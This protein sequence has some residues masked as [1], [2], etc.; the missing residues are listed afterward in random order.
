M[1]TH[2]AKFFSISLTFCLLNR[3]QMLES[4]RFE[5]FNYLYPGMIIFRRS[6]VFVF[7]IVCGSE[8]SF[9][10]HEYLLDLWFPFFMF[11]V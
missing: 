1:K 11:P 2:Y 5:G 6:A 4:V 10:Y 7:L 8:V 3:V 9:F